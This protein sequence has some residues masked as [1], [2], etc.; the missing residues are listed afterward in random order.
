MYRRDRKSY[1]DTS[2]QNKSKYHAPS[3]V[4]IQ[5][6]QRAALCYTRTSYYLSQHT[7]DTARV[8]ITVKILNFD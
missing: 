5:K 7:K 1:N 6:N 4:L 2:Q 8:S 3:Q